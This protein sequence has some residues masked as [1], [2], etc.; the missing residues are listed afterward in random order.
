MI[1]AYQVAPVIQAQNSAY[2]YTTFMLEIHPNQNLNCVSI[3]CEVSPEENKKNR[4]QDWEIQCVRTVYGKLNG[5]GT[6]AQI[7]F[8]EQHF[9]HL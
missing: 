1:D 3:S 9:N 4:K 2:N 6:N 7:R 8:S 5:K